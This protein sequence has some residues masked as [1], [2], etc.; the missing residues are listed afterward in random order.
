[1]GLV[2]PHEGNLGQCLSDGVTLLKAGD[3]EGLLERS[4]SRAAAS[5]ASREAAASLPNAAQAREEA[6]ILLAER[7]TLKGDIS[8]GLRKAEQ[9]TDGPAASIPLADASLLPLH[10]PAPET[11]DPAYAAR[12]ASVSAFTDEHHALPR[13]PAVKDKTLGEGEV[14]GPAF[15]A[16][17]D[18]ADSTAL[19]QAL[20]DAVNKSAGP[21]RLS[22]SVLSSLLLDSACARK[23]TMAV[24]RLVQDG[25]L[26]PRAREHVALANLIG[27]V[28]SDPGAPT[29]ALR[30]LAIADILVRLAATLLVRSNKAAIET[31][32]GRHQYGTSSC[33]IEACYVAI[34]SRLWAA[35]SG[36][37]STL[38]FV[39]LELDI[40][41]AFN[42]GLREAMLCGCLERL[43]ALLR[44]VRAFYASPTGLLYRLP[45]GSAHRLE[46]A[47][48]SRQGD[49]FG[50]VLFNLIFRVVLDKLEA[51]FPD[52]M[53][54]AFMD[55]LYL[56]APAE[57]AAQAAGRSRGHLAQGHPPHP[58]A[59]EVH[60]VVPLPP[61][62]RCRG[63]PRRRGRP[64]GSHRP[65]PRGHRGGSPFF[66]GQGG[67]RGGFVRQRRT[68]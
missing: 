48:G 32:G 44:M 38:H 7:L 18:A 1:M 60:R 5:L 23:A 12:M 10:P 26:P 33:G 54:V 57:R 41:N 64:G 47:R 61:P 2:P 31:S 9:R 4:R 53:Q 16:A 13:A 42:E 17:C 14:S 6:R 62:A 46:S 27:L 22:P 52:V 35:R 49:P 55:N 30:P 58:Q 65:F 45:D 15:E 40:R 29:V 39:V 20:S 25:V 51:H 8:G 66:M 37:D 43:P 63:C 21:D 59:G 67:P 56:V 68:M 11:P 36:P 3:I 19:M 34:V 50:G 24:L 28:K